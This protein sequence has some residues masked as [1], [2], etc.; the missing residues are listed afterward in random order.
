MGLSP[1]LLVMLR[2]APLSRLT[3]T[4]LLLQPAS[5]VT[6]HR[7]LIVGITGDELL[8][9]KQYAE[10]L[11]SWFDIADLDYQYEQ[12]LGMKAESFVSAASA[13]VARI[14]LV[15]G[16]Q[17]MN[18]HQLGKVRPQTKLQKMIKWMR[19]QEFKPKAFNVKE[20]SADLCF[21]TEED[22][23]G[24]LI[25]QVVSFPFPPPSLLFPVSTQDRKQ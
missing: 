8:K 4:G 12:N 5:T 7:R 2:S 17:K 3:A 9:N 14:P 25:E 13:S 19:K 18:L 16:S 10:Y 20:G 15:F 22:L 24:N 1:D 21:L 6:S 11:E 23:D